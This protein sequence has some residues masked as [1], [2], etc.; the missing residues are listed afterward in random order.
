[1]NQNKNE[2][3]YDNEEGKK[4]NVVTMK[5]KQCSP[6]KYENEKLSNIS[7]YHGNKNNF[8]TKTKRN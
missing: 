5:R 2:T 1:M 3:L 6:L 4:A 8:F 7:L